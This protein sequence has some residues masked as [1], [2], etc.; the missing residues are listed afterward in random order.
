MQVRILPISEIE[1]VVKLV[2]TK[3]KR[4]FLVVT[5]KIQAVS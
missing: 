2:D 3:E 5:P 4:L 1:I